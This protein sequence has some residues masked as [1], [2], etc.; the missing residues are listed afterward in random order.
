MLQHAMLPHVFDCSIVWLSYPPGSL[1]TCRYINAQGT[2]QLQ[3]G[4]VKA[5]YLAPSK[6]L[7]QVRRKT[8]PVMHMKRS[9]CT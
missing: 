2:F 6:A 4:T 9:M 7:V 1:R 3:P 8:A 5:V